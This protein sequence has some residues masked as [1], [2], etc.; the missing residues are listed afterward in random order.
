MPRRPYVPDLV[1]DAAY[2]KQPQS[3]VG[4]SET[5][6][7]V[8]GNVVDDILTP[9]VRNALVPAAYKN[10]YGV[11]NSN[12]EQG[13]V[14]DKSGDALTSALGI[15]DKTVAAWR[16]DGFSLQLP[17]I[18]TEAVNVISDVLDT[19]IGFMEAVKALLE[20]AAAF[21]LSLGD[22]LKILI[23]NLKK[24]L[25]EMLSLFTGKTGVYG[26]HIPLSTPMG[27]DMAA[28]VEF[29]KKAKVAV[30]S[31]AAKALSGVDISASSQAGRVMLGMLPDSADFSGTVGG[32]E[33]F[34]S[35]LRASLADPLD[36]NKPEFG[37]NAWVGGYVVMYGGTD[38]TRLLSVWNNLKSL[39]GNLLG[40][41]PGPAEP[42]GPKGLALEVLSPKMTAIRGLAPRVHARWDRPTIKF[43]LS[44]FYP[45]WEPVEDVV[46]AMPDQGE[47]TAT[48]RAKYLLRINGFE[49]GRQPNLGL[50]EKAVYASSLLPGSHIDDT[51]T[52]E[53][54][55]RTYVYRI[56]RRYKYAYS[57]NNYAIDPNTKQT[58][59]LEVLS[60]PARV[61]LPYDASTKSSGALP[62]WF[63]A[64]L[65][66]LLPQCIIDLI[67]D[68]KVVLK[69]LLDLVSDFPNVLLEI[70]QSIMDELQRW[71]DL[72]YR[73][74]A[75]LDLIKSV[76]DIGGGAFAMGFFGLGGNDFLMNTLTSSI[77]NAPEK[78]R[79]M[80]EAGTSPDTVTDSIT[81]RVNKLST[82]ISNRLEAGKFD[83]FLTGAHVPDFGP[84]D[85]VGGFVLMAGDESMQAAMQT[86]K[87]LQTLFGGGEKAKSK[88]AL[89]Y[90]IDQMLQ[91]VGGSVEGGPT[92]EDI[93]GPE[94]VIDSNKM[95]A[96]DMTGTG[97]PG[98]KGDSC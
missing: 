77:A 16:W 11:T 50:S 65:A 13:A 49:T 46:Y 80:S 51:F 4:F 91:G 10:A 96:E 63:S 85:S 84:S 30:K 23:E 6:E 44:N 14:T 34:I 81:T 83:D 74:K 47:Y 12:A 32:N 38:L 36:Y 42:P 68:L 1:G 97:D 31:T 21:M 82:R 61:L 29:L 66:E 88:Q 41:D 52:G 70:I 94:P 55:G 59:I 98:K 33:G 95:F 56:G 75:I 89:Q 15:L 40:S 43:S 72:A 35:T 76:L 7:P 5:M 26:I 9:D 71:I 53:D 3:R 73:L 92:V 62:N 24:R 78:G 25:D 54:L 69:R 87:I 39:F 18:L 48:E 2:P 45:Q 22:A 19:I 20:I 79:S 8:Y 37:P 86:F 64:S 93:L 67:E 57:K 90:D 27:P 60:A 28:R 58:G 17:S